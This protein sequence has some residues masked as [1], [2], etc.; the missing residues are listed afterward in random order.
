MNEL[1]YTK[2]RIIA[3]I[4]IGVSIIIALFFLKPMYSEYISK[5][6]EFIQSQKNL[7]EKKDKLQTLLKLKDS[8]KAGSW[9]DDSLKK[10]QKLQ[11]KWDN[12]DVIQ[13]IML[14]KFTKITAGTN[15]SSISVSSIAVS[16]WSKL[17]NGLSFWSVT[18]SIQSASIEDIIEYVTSITMDSDYVFT[19]DSISLPIDTEPDQA[20]STGWYGLTLKLWVYYFE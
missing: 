12:S 11:K 15:T 9:A 7:D 18:V 2:N 8:F 20:V 16:K 3:P 6:A 4:I 19:L 5:N 1:L 13:S 17:P 14:N 10:I